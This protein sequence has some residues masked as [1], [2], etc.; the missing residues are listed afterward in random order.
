M[1]F[2]HKAFLLQ[3]DLQIFLQVSP[4]HLCSGFHGNQ[5]I[6]SVWI[7]QLPLKCNFTDDIQVEI[8]TQRTSLTFNETSDLSCLFR[9][10]Y[11]ADD[12]PFAFHSAT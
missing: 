8:K 4:I 11:D 2:C 6:A 9:T 3:D 10:T 7:G 1:N 5:H 12:K